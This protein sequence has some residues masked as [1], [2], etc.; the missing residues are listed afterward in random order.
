MNH[1]SSPVIAM[2]SDE[3]T[4]TPVPRPASEG[5]VGDAGSRSVPDHD[6]HGAGAPQAASVA[7]DAVVR[8]RDAWSGWRD[9][10]PADRAG[11]LRAAAAVVRERADELAHV[12]CDDTG[13][14]WR[15]AR[16]S[17]VVAA[18]LLDEAAVTGLAG[19]RALAGGPG[20]VDLVR[21]EPRGVV[22]VLTPW[23]DPYPA[24][25]GLLAAALVTGNTVVH[26]PSE[27]SADSGRLLTELL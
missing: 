4:A 3:A 15:D 27:R 26:K 25:A 7:A 5:V 2:G 16:A 23:N 13:R 8:A 9:T 21:A 10:A 24:A 11:A 6:A 22:A 12:L 20:A 19:G 14:L 1:S 17:A 18:D